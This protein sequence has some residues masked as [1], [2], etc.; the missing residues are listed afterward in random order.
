MRRMDMFTSVH[1]GLRSVLFDTARRVARNDFR[2]TTSA[3]R[4]AAAV[5]R[6]IGLL[7]EHAD[8]EDRL[9]FPEV[10]RLNAVV[11]AELHGDHVRVDGLQREVEQLAARLPQANEDERL[12]LGQRLHERMNRLVA[13][14]LLHMDREETTANRILWAHRTDAELRSLHGSILRS[15][16]PARMKEWA[17]IMLPALS[18]EE[19][20]PL[21]AGL[22]EI[23][24]AGEIERIVA[25]IP[26]DAAAPA[27]GVPAASAP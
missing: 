15:I 20:A 6:L 23:L 10:E 18:P 25:R 11:F 3:Q 24:S 13:E 12:S 17:E 1:K 2:D 21:L 7:A 16:P 14:H 8:H 22:H 5:Q 19:R 9:V 4:T 26:D 27:S